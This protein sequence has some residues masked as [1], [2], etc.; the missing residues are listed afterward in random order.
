MAYLPGIS[1]VKNINLF[2][3]ILINST[4][5]ATIKKKIVKITVTYKYLT[6][7]LTLN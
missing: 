4:A 5:K 3:L 6:Y 7:S 1:N 2:V